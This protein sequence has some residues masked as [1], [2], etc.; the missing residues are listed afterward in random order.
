[1]PRFDHSL[2]GERFS[3]R[4]HG[5]L[6]ITAADHMGAVAVVYYQGGL[7]TEEQET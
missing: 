4:D 5:Q 3:R 1:M 6:L 2:V 7:E